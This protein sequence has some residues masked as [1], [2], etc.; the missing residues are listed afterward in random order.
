[1]TF[2]VSPTGNDAHPGTTAEPFATLTGA[3]DA[4]REARA[5]GEAGTVT[6]ELSGG[7]YRLE[8]TLVFDLRDSAG[9]GEGK[10][11]FR[12]ASGAAAVVGSGAP[13]GPWR[14]V[15]AESTPSEV[16]TVAR[17][18]LW[19]APF[20]ANVE[21]ILA[22]FDGPN[23][24][25]RARGVPFAID[26]DPKEVDS[27]PR[28]DL[29]FPPGA[30]K[31][32]RN[33]GSVEL[34][35]IPMHP[36]TM[37]ILG[38]ESVDTDSRVARLDNDPIYPLARAHHGISHQV[39]PE[40]VFEALDR[41]GRWVSDD[42]ERVV[43]LWP[44]ADAPSESIVTPTLRELVRVEGRID[45][46]S[47]EDEPVR[48]IEFHGLTFTHGRRD[49][50]DADYHGTGLQ[51]NWEFFDRDNAMVRFRGAERCGLIG[52]RLVDSAS[53]G[54][55]FDLHCRHNR[56]VSC[57]IARIGGTGVL[58]QGYGPGKKDV[59]S[60]NEILDN[61]IHH[62]GIDWWHNLG[63]FVWQSSHNRIAGNTIHHTGY[64]AICV[65]GRIIFDR[66]GVGE[67]SKSVRWNEIE[68]D[69]ETGDT[70][71]SISAWWYRMEP[72]LHSRGNLIERNEIYRVM[73]RLGDGNAVYISGCGR[74]N[75]VRENYIHD[76][77][78]PG[79]NAMIRT[80]D[81]QYETLIEKN[82]VY[83]CGGP[84]VYLKHKNHFVNNV[85]VDLGV[86]D[87]E[88]VYEGTPRF[89]GYIG[90]RR[91][92]IHGSRVRRNILYSTSGEARIL[93]EG[94]AGRPSWGES[95][96]RECDA[97]RNLYYSPRNPRWATGFLE[98]KR[99]EGVEVDSI[100][101]DPRFIDPGVP[102]LG[103]RH[104][105]PAIIAL[106]FE[107]FDLSDVGSSLAR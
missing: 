60:H 77:F 15:P 53:G 89:T 8:E 44:E 73:E 72:Y 78:G 61:H 79:S 103:L 35:I 41:P 36:W 18:K 24:I 81:L 22:L 2:Y 75:V 47:P 37:N 84:G 11:E 65:T 3:R 86:D 67:A 83:R 106:G 80:D 102:A 90:L 88:G 57:E 49:T 30:L 100:Q 27:R 52:C 58:L 39:W 68:V 50:W 33:L 91:A 59:N 56:V 105:S 46:D 31:R 42:A 63:V 64:T 23:R 13:V 6:V 82:L 9:E 74:D 95:Y 28:R 99:A 87:P 98:Q 93:W 62:N 71:E 19:K 101:A 55:R 7:Y 38:I 66:A 10:T 26:V 92:P 1:M 51:H 12:A 85:L 32:Y 5:R 70:P 96:L 107:P 69:T 34:L 14:R 48:G 43:Y 94:P 40:N 54:V 104:D 76:I 45:R 21:K 25:A 17:G 16:P 97:D 20:P 4:V 29:R